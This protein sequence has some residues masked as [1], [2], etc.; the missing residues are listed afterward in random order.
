MI[1]ATFAEMT[2]V[3][4]ATSTAEIA[5]MIVV[6]TT[7]GTTDEMT[8]AG[9]IATVEVETVIEGADV[10]DEMTTAVM[11]AGAGVTTAV[12]TGVT[13][14]VTTAAG[15]MTVMVTVMMTAMTAVAQDLAQDRDRSHLL[16]KRIFLLS[17]KGIPENLVEMIIRT[18]PRITETLMTD[19][20]RRFWLAMFYGTGAFLC[21]TYFY[22]ACTLNKR[23]FQQFVE[24]SN[25]AIHTW[26]LEECISQAMDR[27]A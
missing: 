18:Q 9:M 26:Y 23:I 21:V 7:A 3:T 5:E 17:A 8:T 22:S 24:E 12:T 1:V 19:H 11:T 16:L 13:T 27:K 10:T 2:D 14:G 20:G 4:A 15:T 6:I 25:Y